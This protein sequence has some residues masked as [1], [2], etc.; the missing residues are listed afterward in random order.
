MHIS[1]RIITVLSSAALLLSLSACGSGSASSAAA[2]SSAPAVQTV[3]GTA[4]GKNGDVAV[5]VSLE[6]NKITGITVTDQQETERVSDAAL[7]KVSQRIVEANSVKVDAVAGAT[8]TSE[9]IMNAVSAPIESAGLNPADFTAVQTAE[10]S[11]VAE[12][13]SIDTDLVVAEAGGA[14]MTAALQAKEDRVENVLVIEKM[15]YVGGATAM[16]S[17]STLAV[18][19]HTQTNQDSPEM[20]LEDLLK[21]GNNKN[22]L[23]PVTIQGKGIAPEDLPYF[24]DRYYQGSLSDQKKSSGLGFSIAREIIQK[25]NGT[26]TA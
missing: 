12:T 1:K 16:S 24:F 21:A 8:I 15:S 13:E 17:S 5:E 2:A 23:V 19:T 7:E 10:A 18:N 11:A 22:D 20:A 9:A 3:T 4:A 25:E 14:G 26:I 6:G